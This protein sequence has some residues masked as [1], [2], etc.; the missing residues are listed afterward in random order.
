MTDLK[1]RQS[2]AAIAQETKNYSNFSKERYLQD[3]KQ[4]YA[5]RKDNIALIKSNDALSNVMQ[6][7][8]EQIAKN[9][10]VQL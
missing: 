10:G 9:K 2:F 8:T 5:R 3:L 4:N 6:I 1:E 7:L